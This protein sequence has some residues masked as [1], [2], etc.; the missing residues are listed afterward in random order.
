MRSEAKDVD[1]YIKGL[2]DERKEAVTWLRNLVREVHPD[3]EESMDYGMPT[4]RKG[5]HSIAIA[6]QKNYISL[7][8]FDYDRIEEFKER[9]GKVSTGRSCIRFRKFQHL[10]KDAIRE[11]MARKK[12]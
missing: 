6:S 10:N 5:P 2:K 4:Y 3:F 1:I 12:D 11:M 9:L 8:Y 7:Y